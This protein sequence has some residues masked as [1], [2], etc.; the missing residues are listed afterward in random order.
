M[1]SQRLQTRLEVWG[2]KLELV[3][4]ALEVEMQKDHL[5]RSVG[6]LL[7]LHREKVICTNVI[8]ELYALAEEVDATSIK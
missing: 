6:L 2:E 4:H 1:N 8:S 3:E 7:F 5:S